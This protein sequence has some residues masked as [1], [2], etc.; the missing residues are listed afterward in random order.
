MVEVWGDNAVAI[1]AEHLITSFATQLN[2]TIIYPAEPF[3]HRRY[4]LYAVKIDCAPVLV[5]PEKEKA[6][7]VNLDILCPVT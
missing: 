4:S 1:Q 2:I 6:I 3:E 5:L 7:L